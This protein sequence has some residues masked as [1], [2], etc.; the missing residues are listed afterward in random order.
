MIL[1][2][3]GGASTQR[4]IFQT[5]RQS[6]KRIYSQVFTGDRIAVPE[7]V[8]GKVV[9][10]RMIFEVPGGKMVMARLSDLIS[11]G[12]YKLPNRVENIGSG[13]EYIGPGLER[14]NQGVSGTK[15]VVVV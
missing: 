10:G 5:L 3:V 2:A 8:E 15:L 11:E 9:F 7:D 1:D 13:F 6:G 12:R 14:L 4:E